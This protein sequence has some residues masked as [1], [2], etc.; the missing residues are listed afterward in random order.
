MAAK[1]EL[2]Q[3]PSRVRVCVV[4]VASH[5]SD[6]KQHNILAEL[7]VCNLR[8]VG[9]SSLRQTGCVCRSLINTLFHSG[10]CYFT[11]TPDT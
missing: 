3:Q 8:V 10:L 11:R 9:K 1:G 2:Q 7:Q 6:N 5:M 4:C